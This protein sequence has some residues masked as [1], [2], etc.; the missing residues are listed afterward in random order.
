M[1]SLLLLFLIPALAFAQPDD[2]RKVKGSIR[3]DVQIPNPLGNGA[4]RKS[5]VGVM[6]SA[7]GANINFGQ[8]SLGAYGKYY[9]YK[10]SPKKIPAADLSTI[11]MVYGF[12]G[13]LGFDRF[14]SDRLIVSG[15]VTLGYNYIDYAYISCKKALPNDIVFNAVDWGLFFK[16]SY[17]VSDGVAL[18]FIVSVNAM[19]FE[20]KPEDICLQ[21]YKLFDEGSKDGLTSS[22]SFGFSITYDWGLRKILSDNLEYE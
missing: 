15:G 11:Q 5:F 9:Q 22:F 16:T 14:K 21:E 8:I 1:R 6:G 3:A 7:L 17:L 10:I 12:G 19:N 4:F 18:G 13:S 20:F 2:K